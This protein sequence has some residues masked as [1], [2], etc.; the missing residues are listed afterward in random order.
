MEK[1]SQ[2]KYRETLLVI[3]LGFSLLYLILDRNWMLYTAL[4]AGIAGMLSMQLNRW[5][6]VGWLLIGE[7][8]GFV[9][10]KVILGAVFFF[11][12]MPMSLRARLFSKDFMNLKPSSGSG[13]FQRDHQY[14]GQDL[15][16]MW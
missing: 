8:M 16:E 15:D 11:V 12:L 4:S 13:Y 10:S 7:K 6:H 9:V 3:V 1:K 2:T 14:C 5:I